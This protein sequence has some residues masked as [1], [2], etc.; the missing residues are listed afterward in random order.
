MV[1]KSFNDDKLNGQ[2]QEVRALIEGVQESLEDA[3]SSVSDS[4]SDTS[5]VGDRLV[6]VIGDLRS[7]YVHLRIR[8][9]QGSIMSLISSNFLKRIRWRLPI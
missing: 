7:R 5:D 3:A 8:L 2:R 4:S 6:E 9:S 1:G